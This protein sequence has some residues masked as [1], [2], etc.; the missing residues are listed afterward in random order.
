MGIGEGCLEGFPH[1][2]KG[3]VPSKAWKEE[4]RNGKWTVTD[5]ILVSIG[6]GAVLAS[7]LELAVAVARLAGG[8]KRLMP[9]LEGKGPLSFLDMGYEPRHLDLILTAM[10][11]TTNSPSGTAFPSRI[12]VQGMEMAGK[13]GTSQVRRITMEQRRAGQTKTMHLPWKYREH[14]LFIGYAPSHAPRYAIAVVVEHVGG[15][16]RA[17]QAARDILL[18]VQQLEIGTTP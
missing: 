4:R 18:K 1:L 15:S 3:L 5:T 11:A 10:T 8:G 6:Q 2:K 13:T 12:P 7:P 17:V 14:G 16:T 9:R